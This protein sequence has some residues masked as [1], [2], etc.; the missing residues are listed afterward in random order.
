MAEFIKFT[1]E[2][3]NDMNLFVLRE[4]GRQIGVKAPAGMKKDKL[5]QDSIA[6]QENRLEPVAPTKI[7]APPKNPIDLSEYYVK[8]RKSEY[9]PY[10]APSY[11]GNT[12]FNDSVI[13]DDYDTF[14]MEG[15]LEQVS[16][17]FGFLRTN[18]SENSSDD[19]FVSMQI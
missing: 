9:E 18:N 3:L 6:I 15:V 7:G 4:I 1:K 11:A 2:Q 17:N 13:I 5:I 8:P 19:V 16:A 10:N 14:I 12:S